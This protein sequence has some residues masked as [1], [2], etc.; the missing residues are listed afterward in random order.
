MAQ[1]KKPA[2]EP[3]ATT[4]DAPT[5]ATRVPTAIWV[6][7]KLV[8]VEIIDPPQTHVA[9]GVCRCAACHGAAYSDLAARFY[10][11]K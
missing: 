11:E 10:P 3:A 6:N 9:E 8:C 7:D 1:R 4:Q 2:A 5:E